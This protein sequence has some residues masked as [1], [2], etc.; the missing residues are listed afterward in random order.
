MEK[1]IQGTCLLLVR[2]HD[3]VVLDL[4]VSSILLKCSYFCLSQLIML[5]TLLEVPLQFGQNS[6]KFQ[7]SGLFLNQNSLKL[8]V[9][10]LNSHSLLL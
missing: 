4:K 8:F 6:L 2:V 3:Q 1:L 5:P 7:Q 10:I 9:L